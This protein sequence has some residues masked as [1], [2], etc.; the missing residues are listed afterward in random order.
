MPDSSS[1][2]SSIRAY[3]RA[4]IFLAKAISSGSPSNPFWASIQA[5]ICSVLSRGPLE[6]HNSF[7]LATISAGPM[8]S[9]PR[10]D[11]FSRSR[12][13]ATAPLEDLLDPHYFNPSVHPLS[14]HL[15]STV[16]NFTDEILT[17]VIF[18]PI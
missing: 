9:L 18:F 3:W 7:R 10:L 17:T 1:S 15:R 16:Q 4:F 12:G 6:A 8:D 13:P 5:T 14:M 2:K 11:G